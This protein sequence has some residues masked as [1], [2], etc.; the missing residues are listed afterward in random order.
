MTGAAECFPVVAKCVID[1]RA[2]A[3]GVCGRHHDGC[4]VLMTSHIGGGVG[5]AFGG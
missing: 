2:H 5:A 4:A 1:V 3:T